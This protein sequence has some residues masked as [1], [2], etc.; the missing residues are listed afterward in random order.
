LNSIQDYLRA[1]SIAR[2]PVTGTAR[3]DEN[4]SI[5]DKTY[6]I[7]RKRI[8]QEANS[9]GDTIQN[10]TDELRNWRIIHGRLANRRKLI[11]GTNRA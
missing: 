6:E 3:G 7:N 5:E 9:K 4:P 2:W 11:N 10:I 8:L 1:E